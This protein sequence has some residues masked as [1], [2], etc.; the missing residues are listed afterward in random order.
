MWEYYAPRQSLSS[1]DKADQNAGIET[2]RLQFM[3]VVRSAQSTVDPSY[4]IR[5]FCR[6]FHTV[7]S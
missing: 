6:I 2:I 4:E 7:F 5:H 1:D 3:L